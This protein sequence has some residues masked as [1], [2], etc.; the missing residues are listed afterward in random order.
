D[1]SKS[2]FLKLA[3]FLKKKIIVHWIGTDV[4]TYTKRYNET[5]KVINK[6]CINL[7]VS[8]HLQ[9]ELKNIK[10]ESV[11]VPIFPPDFFCETIPAP[12]KH[13]VLSY[14]PEFREDFYGISLVKKIAEHFK[15]IDFYIIANEGKN[16]TE[17]LPNMY[18]SGYLN[19]TELKNLYAK[20]SVLFRF[21][22]HD[23]LPV[24]MLEA[25]GSGR[26]VVYCY[27]FPY[28]HTPKS[29]DVNDIIETF[30]EIFNSPPK[31]NSEAVDYVKMNYSMERQ[32]EIYKEL[33]IL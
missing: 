15:N 33:N 27:N 23:G 11:V 9:E 8:D 17:K 12:K 26:E 7:V 30:N 16:D 31:E 28:V 4:L 32:I 22:E 19:A 13:S 2:A 14:I 24:M 1:I 21:P 20:C 3:M 18:Y 10:I 5:K 29:R 25:L 6:N